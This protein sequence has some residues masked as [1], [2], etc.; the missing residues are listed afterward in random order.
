MS[1]NFPSKG[2]LSPIEVEESL[3]QEWR[4]TLTLWMKD[5]QIEAGLIRRIRTEHAE[6]EMFKL[7]CDEILWELERATEAF[8]AEILLEIDQL[9]A[10]RKLKIE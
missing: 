8:K 3:C 1:Q 10:I 2:P 4:D 9:E 7:Q 6:D 5:I